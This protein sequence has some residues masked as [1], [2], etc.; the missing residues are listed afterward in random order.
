[1]TTNIVEDILRVIRENP[2]AK[3]A[4]RRELLTEELL[5]LPDRFNAFVERVDALAEQVAALTGRVDAITDQLDALTRRVDALTEQV[6]ALT[7][8]VDALTVRV[9]ALTVQVTTLVEQLAAL[10]ERVDDIEHT[11]KEMLTNQEEIIRR[12]DNHD[13][14]FDRIESS[15]QR[16]RGHYALSISRSKA[17]AIVTAFLM[18]NGAADDYLPTV[19]VLSWDHLRPYI[20]EYNN[21]NGSTEKITLSQ[22][23]RLYNTDMIL[24]V[25]HDS[26]DTYYLAVEVS[27]TCDERDTNR[28]SLSCE[29]LKRVMG[30]QALPVVAGIEID[31][32]IEPQIKDGSVFWYQVEYEGVEPE[33]S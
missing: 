28:A 15:L 23:M 14:R 31:R 10:V 2:E 30:R 5:Q 27:Y 26:G 8:R 33:V 22:G 20:V 29:L 25:E 19:S 6:A 4:L 24:A 11:Q 32:R 16:F 9:D 18:A 17:Y 21:N 7:V 13:A 3:A 1:M 12:L